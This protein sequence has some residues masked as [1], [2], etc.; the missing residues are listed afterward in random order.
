MK[1]G[2]KVECIYVGDIGV[3]GCLFLSVGGIYTIDEVIDSSRIRIVETGCI[4]YNRRF[5]LI[6][7]RTNY[8]KRNTNIFPSR[9]ESV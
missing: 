9:K 6:K 4:Y 3:S 5:K 2:D 8:I 7:S 1:P